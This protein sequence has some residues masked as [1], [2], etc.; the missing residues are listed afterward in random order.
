VCPCGC[1]GGGWRRERK[2][3]RCLKNILERLCTEDGNKK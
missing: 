2:S 1:Q 3:K